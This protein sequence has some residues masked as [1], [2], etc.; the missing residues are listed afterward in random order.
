VML[1]LGVAY[2][3]LMAERVRIS[4]VT[5]TKVNP[6]RELWLHKNEEANFNALD[7]AFLLVDY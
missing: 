1:D 3:A 5:L 2:P 7:D 4:R 6:E